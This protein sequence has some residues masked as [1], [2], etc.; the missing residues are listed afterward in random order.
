[1]RPTGLTVKGLKDQAKAL[2]A[3]RA[4]RGIHMTHSQ[5]LERVARLNGYRT[6]AAAKA[7]IERDDK[8][9]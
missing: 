7:L 6:Y 2:R 9:Q 4:M 5:A 1:M 8:G 3:V